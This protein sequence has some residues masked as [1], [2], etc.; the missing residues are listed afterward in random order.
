MADGFGFNAQTGLALLGGITEGLRQDEKENLAFQLLQDQQNKENALKA[1]ET[2]DIGSLIDLQ[3][4]DPELFKAIQ[5]IQ[6]NQQAQQTQQGIQDVLQQQLGGGTPGLT[7]P[8]GIVAGEGINPG[9]L[10]LTP[11]GSIGVQP[12]RLQPFTQSRQDKQRDIS[13]KLLGFGKAGR[14]ALSSISGIFDAEN[15]QEALQAK[16]DVEDT[17][18]FALKLDRAKTR[19]ARNKLIEDQQSEQILDTGQIDQE[20]LRM[21]N[22]TDDELQGEIISDLA[23]GE[24]LKEFVDNRLEAPVVKPPTT[25]ER[26]V[27]SEIVTEQFDPATNA[28][29]ELSRA[30]R[31]QPKEATPV[32]VPDRPTLIREM[33][34]VGITPNSPEGRKIFRELKSKKTKDGGKEDLPFKVPNGFR[35]L[36]PNDANKGVTAIKGGPKDNLA[37]ETAAKLQ[38]LKTAQSSLRGEIDPKTKKPKESLRSLIFDKDGSL[39]RTNLFTAGFNIPGTEGRKLRN[40]ME[41]AIQAITRAETGAAM[42]AEEI[43]NTRT[44]FMPQ[45]GDSVEIVENKLKRLDEFLVGAIR[46]I[47]PPGRLSGTAQTGE[48]A[49]IPP[50]P[51]GFVTG[52][53][54]PPPQGFVIQGGQ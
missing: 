8:Q 52:S 15:E 41:F 19:E 21:R 4:S 16:Q 26:K 49:T 32:K 20:L 24:N 11:G 2:G 3:Q 43:D 50:P 18:I 12:S 25:R 1:S 35:L 39:N 54:P 38:M 40:R 34:A 9:Q 14:D 36:D 37:A 42:P 46:L 30:P 33:E 22:M 23:I 47:A 31:F 44:R 51:T 28:F 5:G 6:A 13:L 48:T 10:A 7:E 17:Q 27:G 45:V 29:T 53:I